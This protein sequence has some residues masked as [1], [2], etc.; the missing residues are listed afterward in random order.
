[1]RLQKLKHILTDPI[2]MLAWC[3]EFVR[4][5]RVIYIE[6]PDGEEATKDGPDR[7]EFFIMHLHIFSMVSPA[8]MIDRA[9]RA[10]LS[11]IERHSAGYHPRLLR[12]KPQGSSLPSRCHDLTIP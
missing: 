11:V 9:S 1:M 2:A 3:A 10:W 5:G 6:V 4:D 7:H 8:M 12:L